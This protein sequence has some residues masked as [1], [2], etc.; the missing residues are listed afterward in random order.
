MVPQREVA[1]AGSCRR[2]DESVT[3]TGLLQAA[4]PRYNK[5][6]LKYSTKQNSNLAVI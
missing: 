3:L 2:L 6:Q 1:A 4:T 5:R